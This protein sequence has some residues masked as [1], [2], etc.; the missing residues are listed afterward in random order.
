MHV[1]LILNIGFTNGASSCENKSVRFIRIMIP[2]ITIKGNNEGIIFSNQS[3]SPFKEKTRHLAGNNKIIIVN[4]I[5]KTAV[6]NIMRFFF[7]VVVLF[8]FYVIIIVMRID[9]LL[10][11]MNI[12]SRS[13]VKNLLKKGQILVNGTKVVK[14][15]TKVDEKT[16]VISYKNHDYQFKPFFYY[17]LN[18]PA[19]TVSATTDEKETT[20]IDLLKNS[21]ASINE[22]GLVGIPIHDIF[23][24]GRLDKDTVG[25]LILTNDGQLAHNLLSPKKHVPKKYYVELDS[26]LTEE[27]IYLLENGVDI[28][29][30]ELTGKANIE[31]ISETTCYI[32]ISEGKFHQVKRMFGTVG[33]H[34]NYLKRLSMGNLVL[35]SNLKEGEIRPLTQ[36]E[37][38]HLC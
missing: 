1:L 7:K 12:G 4:A 31:K 3:I 15:D 20:V 18:K 27:N 16:A 19:G 9:K 32:T 33:L 6:R 35:D 37:V 17:M 11:E 5:V 13:E 30:K 36:E 23:P 38:N 24:V 34:V 29:E 10:C 26:F 22:N 8:L 25:L 14:P 2:D 28:G 21:L